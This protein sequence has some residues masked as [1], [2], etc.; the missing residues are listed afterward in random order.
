MHRRRLSLFSWFLKIS[1]IHHKVTL[2]TQIT[3]LSRETFR[4]LFAESVRASSCHRSPFFDLSK[5]DSR[6]PL[7][8][9]GTPTNPVNLRGICAEWWW[10]STTVTDPLTSSMSSSHQSRHHSTYVLLLTL[11]YSFGT[12]LLQSRHVRLN[13]RMIRQRPELRTT[14]ETS[15]DSTTTNYSVVALPWHTCLQ[16]EWWILYSILSPSQFR[17]VVVL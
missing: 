12:S 11:Y 16:S 8:S 5:T 3:T 7:V 2:K 4:V 17:Q 6:C 13:S 14:F 9:L 1:M 10:L 15:K